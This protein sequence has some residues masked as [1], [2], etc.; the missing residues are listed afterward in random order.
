MGPERSWCVSTRSAWSCSFLPVEVNVT[1]TEV[2]TSPDCSLFQPRIRRHSSIHNC[3]IGTMCCWCVSPPPPPA[4]LPSI[5]LPKPPSLLL[6]G[7]F[8]RRYCGRSP[9]IGPR[10]W[11][12]RKTLRRDEKENLFF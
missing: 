7:F 12:S 11:F 9:L 1:I 3:E 4:V 8:L 2:L 5:L 6:L 10:R